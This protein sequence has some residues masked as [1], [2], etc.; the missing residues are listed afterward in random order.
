MT[1]AV[2]TLNVD[3]EVHVILIQAIM[4][5]SILFNIIMVLFTSVK[6]QIQ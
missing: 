5:H 4:L 2:C 6:I 3:Y 1:S